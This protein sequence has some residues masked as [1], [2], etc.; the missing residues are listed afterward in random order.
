MFFIDGR[1]SIQI[2]HFVDIICYPNILDCALLVVT[3]FQYIYYYF[4]ERPKKELFSDITDIK[5]K[6]K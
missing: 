3:V 4:P 1:I 5:I 6:I 2:C